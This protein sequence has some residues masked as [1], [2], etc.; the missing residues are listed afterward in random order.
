[1]PQATQQELELQKQE[2]LKKQEA[3]TVE[4]VQELYRIYKNKIETWGQHAQ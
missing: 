2:A 1:M 3:E 4:R